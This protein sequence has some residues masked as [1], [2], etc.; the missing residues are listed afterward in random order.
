MRYRFCP[1]CGMRIAA[2]ADGNCPRCGRPL[3]S[4]QETESRPPEIEPTPPEP[5]PRAA[6]AA[7]PSAAARSEEPPGVQTPVTEAAR[8]A[9]QLPLQD[10]QFRCPH[11]GEALYRGEQVCWNCGRRVETTEDVRTPAAPLPSQPASQRG[12]RAEVA[13]AEYVPRPSQAAMSDAYWALGLGLVSALTCGLG[14]ILG[15]IAL[16]LGIRGLRS[17]AGPVAVAG[18]VFGA[19]GTFVGLIVWGAVVIWAIARGAPGELWLYLPAVRGLA[20]VVTWL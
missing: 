2:S 5:A 20:Q 3:G 17:G 18:I 6:Q 10:G 11:C 1:H 19:I 14:F 4:G 12:W 16:W 9:P 8:G 13:P 7:E 15:P